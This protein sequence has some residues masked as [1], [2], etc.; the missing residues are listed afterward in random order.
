[1]GLSLQLEGFGL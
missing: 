1:M